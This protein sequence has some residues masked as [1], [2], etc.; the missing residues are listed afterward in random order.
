MLRSDKPK[1]KAGDDM[2]E[3]LITV[4][5]MGPLLLTLCVGVLLRRIGLMDEKLTTGMNQLVFRI[6]L[7]VMLFNNLR[8][9]DISQ[10]PGLGFSG[11]V[12]FGVAGIYLIAQWIVPKFVKDPRRSGVIVQGIFRTN[13]AVL[14]IPL[15]DAMFGDAGLAALSLAMPL[16]VPLNNIL[17]VVSLSATGGKTSVKKVILNVITNPLIIAVLLGLVLLMTGVKLPAMADEVLGDLGGLTSTVSLLV[18]GASLKWQG[19][20]D[21]KRELAVTLVIK[22]LI[23]PAVMVTLAALLGMRQEALGV[24]VILFGAPGAVSSYPMAVAMGADG[25]LAASQLVMTTIC[26]MG[27]LF[28]LIYVGKVLCLL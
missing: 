16:V 9:L 13:F 3:F 21:N 18:L 24:I 12:I 2:Q 6:F 14:G 26:S 10:M 5:I 28:A 1:T 23:L 4:D 7:P 15:M 22:Q 19:V 25:T 17:G 20:K 27:T 11:F 8:T